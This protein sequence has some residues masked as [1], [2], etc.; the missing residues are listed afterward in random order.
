[1]DGVVIDNV[2][3]AG[4][5]RANYGKIKIG[6]QITSDEMLAFV[7]PPGSDLVA[8]F[9][10]AMRAMHDDGT[11]EQINRKWGLSQ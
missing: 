9:N 8:P 1:V 11:L 2:S 4:Y 10:A 6:S 3:A 7:F 5:I